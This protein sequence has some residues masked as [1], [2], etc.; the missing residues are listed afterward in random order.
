MGENCTRNLPFSTKV[1]IVTLMS[2]SNKTIK[3]I[4]EI[5]GVKSDKISR[6]YKSAIDRGFNP[7]KFPIELTE[8]HV[9]S[10]S[11][12]N[13]NSNN[14]GKGK[15]NSFVNLA[16]KKRIYNRLLFRRVK[17]NKNKKL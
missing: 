6:I 14:K 2:F 11:D 9:N 7:E 16:V 13:S 3:E 1:M 8:E 17:L 10:D 15:S 12:S 4:E 5:T